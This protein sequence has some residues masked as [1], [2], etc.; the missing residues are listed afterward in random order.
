MVHPLHWQR[1]GQDC[2]RIPVNP[3]LQREHRLQVSQQSKKMI[4]NLRVEIHQYFSSAISAVTGAVSVQK[5]LDDQSGSMAFYD[6]FFG[7]KAI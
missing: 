7:G 5:L 6:Q 1:W 4:N 2:Q 3:E